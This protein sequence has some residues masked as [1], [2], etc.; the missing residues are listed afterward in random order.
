MRITKI[1]I[2]AA[3][4]FYDI[5]SVAALGEMR[6]LAARYPKTMGMS[7]ERIAQQT[8]LRIV[9]TLQHV[10]LDV[11]G[12]EPAI[13]LV[14]SVVTEGYKTGLFNN[15]GEAI[16]INPYRVEDLMAALCLQRKQKPA[17]IKEATK[18]GL[19]QDP[20]RQIQAALAL[21]PQPR[22][23]ERGKFTERAFAVPTRD[24]ALLQL[25]RIINQERVRTNDDRPT[26]LAVPGIGCNGTLYDLDDE[27]SFMLQLADNGNW[28]YSFDP[29]GMGKNK[30]TF[31][32][33]CFLDT[34]VSN[35]LPAV[36]S[37]IYNSP[38]RKKPAVVVGHSMGGL[39]ALFTVI[40]QAYKLNEIIRQIAAQS[41]K[42]F[43]TVGKTRDEIKKYLDGQETDRA[44][45]GLVAQARVHLEMLYAVK[46]MILLGMPLNF[47][48]YS[49]YIFPGLLMLNILLPMLGAEKVNIDR[50]KWLA[51]Y[52]PFELFPLKSLVNPKNFDDPAKVI[53]RFVEKGT[54]AFSLGIGHQF[55]RAI[56]SGKGIKRM[57]QSK[58]N[59]SANL[60]LVPV[61]IP[62]FCFYGS[63][64]PLG[65]S[66]N[67][68]FIDH[69]YYQGDTLDFSSFPTYRHAKLGIQKLSGS[70]NPD[71]VDLSS[72]LSQ[73]QGFL[74][75]DVSHLDLMYGKIADRLIRPLILRMIESIWQ[76]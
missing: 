27:S 30:G 35:D 50:V 6:R 32:P 54:D 62:I 38:A 60:D 34:L 29:R 23:P 43:T 7:P 75:E 48:R 51:K 5:A 55:L 44:S 67:L 11:T 4:K 47:D 63:L 41:G 46:G 24:N 33:E 18:H 26:V 16:F 15:Y 52:L 20:S 74:I 9:P 49:H 58:F 21:N 36:L 22:A 39:L 3:N 8:A 76:A 28:T 69:G 2:R 73:V 1:G 59:Y 37:F 71:E 66:Y 68:A 45:R 10:I 64:D 70:T 19:L 40:R 31:D 72:E 25:T 42:A 14:R 13:E 53:R 12:A 57:D 17:F 61:D 56:Y 65:A